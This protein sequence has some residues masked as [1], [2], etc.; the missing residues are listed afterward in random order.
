MMRRILGH[1]P[2][3]L[4]LLFS[5]YLPGYVHKVGGLDP[6]YPLEE[7]HRLGRFTERAKQ[8]DRRPSFSADI[9]EGIPPVEP[10]AEAPGYM[11]RPQTLE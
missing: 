4:R 10:P 8:S 1:L 3:D 2:L 6:R 9:R 11:S 7:L 5:G